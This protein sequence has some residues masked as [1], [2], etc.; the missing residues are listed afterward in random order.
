MSA[1]YAQPAPHRTGDTKPAGRI[2]AACLLAAALV[3]GGS[4]SASAQNISSPAMLQWFDGSYRTFE[5]RA[6]DIHAAGYGSM[7]IPPTGRAETGNQSVGY[8]VYDRFDLGSAGNPTLYGTETGLKQ[9]VKTMKR[10]GG[11]VYM[12]LVWNH[13]GFAD[14]ATNGFAAS[15]GY[16]G[17]V[18]SQ[19]GAVDGDFH[20]AFAGGD[21]QM[22]LSGLIDIN[23]TTNFQYVRSPVPGFANNIPAGTTAFFGKLANIPRES[24]RRFYPDQQLGNHPVVF[25]PRT[26]ESNLPLYNF[27]KTAPLSGDPI[28][29]N[30]LGLLMRNARWLVQEVGVDGF[31]LDA[32]K[33]LDPWVLNYLDRAV[34]RAIDKPLLDG[35]R[36]DVFSFGEHLDGNSSLIQQYIRK[37]INPATPGVVGG[38]RD[39]LDFPL[40]F[41]MRNNFTSNGFQN[42]FRNVVNASL[43]RN[44]DG[45]ANNGSQGVAFV[46]SHDDFGPAL[47]NTAHAL[48]LMRPGNA[49]VYFDGNEHG[50]RDFPKEGRGDAVGGLYGN[51]VT[52]LVDIRNRYGRG[53]YQ[54]RWL[55]KEV[56]IFERQNSALV[57]LSNRTDGGYDTRTVN[58]GFAPGTPLVELTGNAA[59]TTVDPT[60]EIFDYVVVAPNGQATIRVPRNSSHSLGYVMYGPATPQGTLSLSNVVQTLAAQTPTAATNGTARLTAVDVIKANTFN[61]TLNTTPVTIPGY[62]RDIPADGDNAI[63]KINDGLDINAN[64][65]VDFVNS[66]GTAGSVSYGFENFATKN[67]PLVGSGGAT[68]GDGQ[69]IQAVNAALL[70]EGFNFI[71]VRAFRQRGINEPAVYSSFKKTVYIDRLAP[72]SAIASFD[73]ISTNSANRRA[74]AQSTDLTA[75]NIHLFLDLPAALTDAQILSQ[76]GGGSQGNGIDR[77]IWTKDFSNLTHGNH[78]LTVVTFEMT[79]TYSILRYPGFFTATSIGLGLG[80]VNFDGQ[81]T[82]SDILRF[83]ELVDARNTL[84][85]PAADINAD[86][87]LNLTDVALLGDTLLNAGAPPEVLAA[88]QELASTVIPE[89]AALAGVSI[90]MALLVRRRRTSQTTTSVYRNNRNRP[91]GKHPKTDIATGKE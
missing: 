41:A 67:S 53:D 63:L 50:N 22:R 34:Y 33:H 51:T 4:L 32:I 72:I 83:E 44:D 52:K 21:L 18:L 27:N 2:A 26:G 7:W 40:F 82:K 24:N 15:G 49:I 46:N 9:Y 16:P 48:V 71:E 43:D 6:A 1:R 55:E 87:L 3:C 78:V 45:L 86:G 36:Q 5:R 10:M 89:P 90:G 13:N 76:L 84:F 23:H 42:D 79:G 91:V 80:D 39:A 61:I 85:N 38:N 57:G 65:A 58:T 77:D 54:E 81:L 70:P 69:F 88:Y 47:S 12:D 75:D 73:P 19:P 8:D 37:D 25:D 30:A 35:R 74:V 17:F 28:P 68:G 64:G 56:L 29:E 62:G 31:R 60:N 59:N 66:T 20:S 14:T 11:N